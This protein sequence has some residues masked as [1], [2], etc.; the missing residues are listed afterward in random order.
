[1]WSY[2]HYM[3]LS[4]LL[5]DR[6]SNALRTIRIEDRDE[7]NDCTKTEDELEL[8]I[9]QHVDA[10]VAQRA[11]E[12]EERVDVVKFAFN[13]DN[14]TALKCP[15]CSEMLYWRSTGIS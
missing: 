13:D 10:V 5:R 11:D 2:H 12:N 3:G 1:M 4:V 6:K 7:F 15:E 9:E 8:S 14:P